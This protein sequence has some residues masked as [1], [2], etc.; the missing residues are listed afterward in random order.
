[1]S[2]TF[3]VIQVDAFTEL[4]LQGNPCAILPDA[5]TLSDDEM[6]AIARE[7]NLSETSF[8]LESDLADFR[9]RYFTPAQE[10]PL[11]GHPTIAT[12][13]A[14][15][16]LGRIA[17]NTEK[18]TIELP[19]G[20][21]GVEIREGGTTPWI[22]MTQLKPEFG[23]RLNRGELATALRV[24]ES[25]VRAD[26]PVQVVS[27]GTPQL[28]VPLTSLTALE[29]AKPDAARV[30][31]LQAKG[32]F[33]SLHA[34]TQETLEPESTAHSRHWAASTTGLFEDPVTGSA[35]GGMISY[36]L[37][38]GLIEPGSHR[39]EQGDTMQRPGRV[40]AEVEFLPDG[41]VAPP[42]IGGRAVTV[43][44]GSIEI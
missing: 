1:M 7:M 43:L 36:M 11:A 12:V 13:H 18:V 37:Q 9:C 20:V 41:S 44:R 4:P 23:R 17:A 21:I 40:E 26:V 39:L 16:E 8:V 32:G 15:R 3:D 25:G 38:Y 2:R 34:F 28:M 35:S 22:V 29:N 30:V 31:E 10:I 42:K 19:A 5:G 27:T 6:Q 14:L 33:F 24:P